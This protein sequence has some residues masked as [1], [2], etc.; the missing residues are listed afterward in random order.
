M[1]IR[2][3][4]LA[5]LE[6][7]REIDGT[8][9]STRYLHLEQ[10]GEGLQS[11]WRLEERPLR[12]KLIDPNRLDDDPYFSLK[13]IVSGAAEGLAV[14]VEYEDQPIALLIA[15]PDEARRTLRII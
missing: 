8:V 5:D 7:V 11:G 15:T 2:P 4:I 13:Q 9:E 14:A 12:A 1:E 10:S 3:A 6:M